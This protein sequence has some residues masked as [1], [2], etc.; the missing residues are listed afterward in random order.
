MTK[1]C[2]YV[3]RSLLLK[4]HAFV[5]LIN[6]MQTWAIKILFEGILPSQRYPTHDD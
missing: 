2:Q 6:V 1:S 5:T 3:E 4:Q